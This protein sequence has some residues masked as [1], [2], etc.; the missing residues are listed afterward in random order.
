M[1]LIPVSE[2][3]HGLL[4][5]QCI[6]FPPNN[7]LSSSKGKERAHPSLLPLLMCIIRPGAAKT[8]KVSEGHSSFFPA[9]QSGDAEGHHSRGG[10]DEKRGGTHSGPSRLAM[11]C[12]PISGRAVGTGGDE[13]ELFV[14]LTAKPPEPGY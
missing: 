3:M 1:I 10:V 6:S 13:I 14:Q 11:W 4:H 9:S 7:L 2:K 12:I 8:R 5:Y